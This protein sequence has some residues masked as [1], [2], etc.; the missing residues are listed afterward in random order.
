[1]K[2]KKFEVKMKI[3][4]QGWIAILKTD[5]IKNQKIISKTLQIQKIFC[6][7]VS[8]TINMKKCENC[9]RKCNRYFILKKQLKKRV[10]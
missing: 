1:M 9:K 5:Q 8:Y 7:L 3:S 4:N 2:L 6:D 10:E